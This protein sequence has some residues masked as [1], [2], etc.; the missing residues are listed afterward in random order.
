MG[1]QLP[2]AGVYGD[3]TPSDLTLK[4][5]YDS[6]IIDVWSGCDV[7]AVSPYF[8]VNPETKVIKTPKNQNLN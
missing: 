4:L 1:I 7:A 3:T 5:S 2:A 8:F 6:R